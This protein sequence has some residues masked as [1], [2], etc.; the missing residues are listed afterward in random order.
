MQKR[1]QE[2]KTFNQEV[3]VPTHL[4]DT[5][6]KWSKKKEDNNKT[7]SPQGNKLFAKHN[8]T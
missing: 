4:S 8:I 3:C 6:N 2:K 5:I 1:K 7:K